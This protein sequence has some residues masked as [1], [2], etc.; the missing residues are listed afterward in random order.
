MYKIDSIEAR[1]LPFRSINQTS[2]DQIF[3]NK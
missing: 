1:L 2:S 3:Q